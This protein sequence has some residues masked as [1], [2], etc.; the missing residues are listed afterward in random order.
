MCRSTSKTVTCFLFIDV[1][2]KNVR[3]EEN[4]SKDVKSI[5]LCTV[6]IQ[7]NSC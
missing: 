7:I 3:Y 6:L 2:V 1:N 4:A 5:Y